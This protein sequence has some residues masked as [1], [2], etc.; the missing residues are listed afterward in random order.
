MFS[1]SLRFELVRDKYMKND[2]PHN[3]SEYYV[4]INFDN[5]DL[6]LPFCKETYCTFDEFRKHLE[7]NL[8][9]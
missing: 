2:D 3:N 9:L 4:R 8:I 1:S 6:K 7:D 5:E